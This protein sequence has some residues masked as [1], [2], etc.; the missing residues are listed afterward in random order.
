ML[1]EKYEP[2]LRN[3]QI[4]DDLNSYFDS[5][6]DSLDFISWSIEGY[7]NTRILKYQ[8]IVIS[9]RNHLSL[10]KIKQIVTSQE[11]FFFQPV[12]FYNVEKIIEKLPSNKAVFGKIPA[13][14]LKEKEFSLE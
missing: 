14:V 4:A 3:R 12:S 13:K 9:Y 11:K 2:F 5:V 10:I 6:K 8:N 7:W 1:I